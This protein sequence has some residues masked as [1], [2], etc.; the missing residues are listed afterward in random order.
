MVKENSIKLQSLEWMTPESY[1][2]KV[3]EKESFDPAGSIGSCGNY[4][5]MY[6]HTHKHNQKVITVQDCGIGFYAVTAD[7]FSS[8]LFCLTKYSL[9][10]VPCK[11]TA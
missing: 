5:H 1:F 11:T 4:I 6:I 7:L 8:M 3:D 10:C 2:C 9:V